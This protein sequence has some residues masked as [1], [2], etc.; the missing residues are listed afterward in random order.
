MM[1]SPA[2][3]KKNNTVFT[4]HTFLQGAIIHLNRSYIYTART[5]SPHVWFQAE[6]VH[7][8]N[9]GALS[10]VWT[11]FFTLLLANSQVVLQQL[12][13]RFDHLSSSHDV[14]DS[15]KIQTSEWQDYHC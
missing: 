4:T 13:R 5:R 7:V 15:V 10:S 2:V 6:V 12:D 14:Q 3:H 9:N 1:I 11:V 8:E